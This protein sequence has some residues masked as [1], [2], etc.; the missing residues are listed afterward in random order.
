M[1]IFVSVTGEVERR[2]ARTAK[3]DAEFFLDFAE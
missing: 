3:L 2:K 1:E